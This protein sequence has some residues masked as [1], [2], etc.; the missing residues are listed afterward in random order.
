LKNYLLALLTSLAISVILGYITIPLL[1]KFKFGQ[2]ILKYV[3]EHKQKSGTPTMGGIF[4]IL[5]TIK[6][7]SIACARWFNG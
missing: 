7:K 2:P 5:S 4:F 1:R 3:S 6:F